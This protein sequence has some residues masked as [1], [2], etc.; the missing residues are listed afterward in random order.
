L[1]QS[2]RDLSDIDDQE[3]VSSEFQF[4]NVSNHQRFKSNRRT[5]VSFGCLT[6]PTALF[7]SAIM[8]TYAPTS[9]EIYL[10]DGYK[11]CVA[12]QSD[13]IDEASSGSSFVP[14]L[15][16]GWLTED[17]QPLSASDNATESNLPNLPV[18]T[19]VP[20]EPPPPPVPS[21]VDEQQ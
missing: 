11:V 17:K 16:R 21:V 15:D 19:Q 20:P 1:I 7:R 10:Q 3:E 14:S 8:T 12:A 4:Y 2:Q 9:S 13:T 18:E 6:S 5:I